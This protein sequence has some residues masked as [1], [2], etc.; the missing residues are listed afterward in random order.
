MPVTTDNPLSRPFH[1]R[2]TA[3]TLRSGHNTEA[4][5]RAAADRANDRAKQLGIKTRYV[6][7]PRCRGSR[8][9]A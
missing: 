9:S 4:E 1:V 5:A 7:A 2:T 3:G 8:R 6:A